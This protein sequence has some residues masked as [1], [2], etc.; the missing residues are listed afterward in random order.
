MGV[1]GSGKSAIGEAL[2]AEIGV[3]YVD[4]DDLHPDSNIAKMS[5]GDPLTDDDRWPWL[6]AVGGE[7]ARAHGPIIVGCSALKRR[8]RDHIRAHSGGSVTFIYLSGSREL[9]ARRMGGRTGH[10]MPT[11]LIDSQFAA[12]EPPDDDENAIAVDIDRPKKAV[13][14]SIVEGLNSLAVSRSAGT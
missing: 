1:A 2:A 4:G 8:Y 12:L 5:R 14:Q 13:V 9:I 6:T 3:V 7:L 11:S 10:F